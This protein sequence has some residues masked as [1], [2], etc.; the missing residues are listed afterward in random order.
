MVLTELG[1][2]NQFCEFLCVAD[3]DRLKPE[4]GAHTGTLANLERFVEE[5]NVCAVF[6][7]VRASDGTQARG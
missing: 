7:N 1:L 4:Y 6:R 2:A 5:H 3:C